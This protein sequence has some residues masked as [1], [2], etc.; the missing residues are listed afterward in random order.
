MNF[1][2][3]KLFPQL[4]RALPETN[5]ISSSCL[6]SLPPPFPCNHKASFTLEDN[7]LDWSS[8]ENVGANIPLF[9][10]DPVIEPNVVVPLAFIQGGLFPCPVSGCLTKYKYA[11]VLNRMM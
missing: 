10:T 3:S 11:V 9:I 6:L 4:V 1:D 2:D 7:S 8:E 5:R